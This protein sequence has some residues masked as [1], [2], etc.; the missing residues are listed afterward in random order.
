LQVLY[1]I[2]VQHFVML[3]GQHPLPLTL[4]DVVAA[5]LQ[6]MTAEVI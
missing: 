2:L 6:P 5:A 1:G 4:L 3:A